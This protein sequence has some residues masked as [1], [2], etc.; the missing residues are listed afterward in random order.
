MTRRQR[1]IAT[2]KR[3]RREARERRPV[4]HVLRDILT[5]RPEMLAWTRR[6]REAIYAEIRALCGLPPSMVLLGTP[7]KQ[8]MS[9]T[10]PS[11]LAAMDVTALRLVPIDSLVKP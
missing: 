2:A 9:P 5:G 7:E 1:K 11:D 10:E 6:Y 4:H 8:G 3:I